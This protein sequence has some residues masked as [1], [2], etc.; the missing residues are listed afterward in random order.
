MVRFGMANSMKKDK[1][2]TTE[3]VTVEIKLPPAGSVDLNGN[4]V[5]YTIPG[6]PIIL[7]LKHEDAESLK[8]AMR[9]HEQMSMGSTVLPLVLDKTKTPEDILNSLPL[10][11]DAES[12]T[13]GSLV[14]HP[15]CAECER[16]KKKDE[17]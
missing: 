15:V 12:F 1:D 11:I 4:V 7:D 13:M 9:M 6:M 2:I 14:Q 3:V 5:D 8:R 17:K 10:S 16:A